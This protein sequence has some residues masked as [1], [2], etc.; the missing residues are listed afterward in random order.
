MSWPEG[1]AGR[2]VG[3]DPTARARCAFSSAISSCSGATA[4]RTSA[5]VK[6]GE[7]CCG[8]FQ[9][10]AWTSISTARSL[11]APTLAG[12]R[13]ADSARSSRASTSRARPMIFSRCWRE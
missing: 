10:K 12:A 3:Q 7:M 4:A 5:S 2:P 8:Q 6:R 9:S 1:Q 13:W 11:G